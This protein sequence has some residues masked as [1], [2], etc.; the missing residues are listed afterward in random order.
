M[1]AP[2][3]VSEQQLRELHIKIDMSSAKSSGGAASSDV[4]AG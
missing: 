3:P 2:A 1:G 4:A